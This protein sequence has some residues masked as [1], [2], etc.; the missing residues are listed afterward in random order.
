M[1][2]APSYSWELA[3]ADRPPDSRNLDF[4][5]YSEYLEGKCYL[6]LVLVNVGDKAGSIV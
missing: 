6:D 1:T 3:G 2:E 5:L 4:R